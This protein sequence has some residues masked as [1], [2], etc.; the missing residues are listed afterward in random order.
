MTPQAARDDLKAAVSRAATGLTL[1]RGNGTR[2]GACDFLNSHRDGPC[3]RCR[4][5]DLHDAELA[6]KR[7]EAVSA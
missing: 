7:G 4:A 3:P 2:Q 5:R 6:R 1:G